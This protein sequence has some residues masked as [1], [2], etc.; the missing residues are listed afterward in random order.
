MA[1]ILVTSDAAT[2]AEGGRVAALLQSVRPGVG[3]WRRGWGRQRAAHT[4]EE[5]EGE[6]AEAGRVLRR[7]RWGLLPPIFWELRGS[8]GTP[9][10]EVGD[11]CLALDTRK[12]APR[13]RPWKRTSPF[14][15]TSAGR[16]VSQAT[17]LEGHPPPY[18]APGLGELR[19]HAPGKGAPRPGPGMGGLP[20]RSWSG[21]LVL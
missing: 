8:H 16:G 5:P 1:S 21:P 10:A 19:G 2:R 12:E 4:H 14:P 20:L 17:P 9:R 15:T 11:L 6:G 7:A 3:A 13:S 18:H